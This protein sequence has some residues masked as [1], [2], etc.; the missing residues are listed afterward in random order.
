MYL[1]VRW[2]DRWTVEGRPL[3]MYI[4][5]SGQVLRSFQ[6]LSHVQG[7]CGGEWWQGSMT[8]CGVIVHC[9]CRQE[10]SKW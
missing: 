1:S 3:Q 8:E 6:M 9:M 7:A 10:G 5:A 2:S 4:Q